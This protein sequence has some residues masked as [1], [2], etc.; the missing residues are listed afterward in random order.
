MDPGTLEIVKWVLIVV[1]AALGIGVT[2]RRVLSK[3][4]VGRARDDAEVSVYGSAMA[5]LRLDRNSWRASAEEAWT[6][7]R[8]VERDLNVCRSRVMF[9]ES[10]MSIVRRLMVKYPEMSTFLPFMIS[11]RAP[12]DSIP[13]PAAS[14]EPPAPR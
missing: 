13:D 4:K 5:E 8:K 9:L 1:S 12:L 11:D 2:G 3:D 7:V 14:D 10:Q 6:R